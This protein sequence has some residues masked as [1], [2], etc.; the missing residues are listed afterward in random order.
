VL[1]AVEF[2]KFWGSAD[3]ALRLFIKDALHFL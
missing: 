1:L 3:Q 2:L